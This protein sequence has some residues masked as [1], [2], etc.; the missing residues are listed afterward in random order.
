MT[1]NHD[2][3]LFLEK[4]RRGEFPQEQPFTFFAYWAWWEGLGRPDD[5]YGTPMLVCCYDNKWRTPKE[6]KEMGW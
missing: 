4:V 2:L 1:F 6:I 3:I 5:Y